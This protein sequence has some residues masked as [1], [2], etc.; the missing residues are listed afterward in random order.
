MLAFHSEM[1]EGFRP[2]SAGPAISIRF[3]DTNAATNRYVIIENI[4]ILM[5]VTNL[6]VQSKLTLEIDISHMPKAIPLR[7]MSMLANDSR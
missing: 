4:P 5:F 3:L 1:S 6:D 7:N 2:A